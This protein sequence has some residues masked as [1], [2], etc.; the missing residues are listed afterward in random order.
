MNASANIG[1]D[2]KIA[3]TRYETDGSNEKSSGGSNL[4]LNTT[5]VNK[6]KDEEDQLGGSKE[7][8]VIENGI[9]RSN[10]SGQSELREADNVQKGVD[11]SSEESKGKEGHDEKEKLRDGMRSKDGV[12]EEGNEGNVVS[13][14]PLR[15]EGSRGEECDSSNMCTDEK[16]K[17]VACLRVPGNG[18]C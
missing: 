8:V 12:K 2:P 11:G 13:S 15:N 3:L 16:N 1:L 18:M 10:S 17:L 5:K 9:D 6:V 14:T 7:G 4:V